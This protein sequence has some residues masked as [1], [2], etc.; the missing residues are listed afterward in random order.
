MTRYDEAKDLPLRFGSV[1]RLPSATACPLMSFDLFRAH[2][3]ASQTTPQS[4][5]MRS[6][7]PLLTQIAMHADHTN[8][9]PVS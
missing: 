1:Q 9:S 4:D 7:D 3:L 5:G 6:W 2:W 8:I